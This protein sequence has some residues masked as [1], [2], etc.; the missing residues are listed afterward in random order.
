MQKGSAAVEN[1]FTVSLT[2]KHRTPKTAIPFVN[3]YP[4]ELKKQILRQIHI[5]C[6]FT[7][8]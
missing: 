8:V 4:K 2:V 7:V 5:T 3:I 6:V 1:D